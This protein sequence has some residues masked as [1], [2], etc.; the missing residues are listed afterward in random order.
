MPD[1]VA[2]KVTAETRQ[3]VKILAAQQGI[4]MWELVHR[5]VESEWGKSPSKD[6]PVPV[7]K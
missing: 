4:E 1:L 5:L 7:S 2:L 3:R 6:Y